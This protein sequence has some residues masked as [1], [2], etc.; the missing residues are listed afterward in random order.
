MSSSILSKRI[1]ENIDN[2]VSKKTNPIDN[3]LT[4][5]K[6]NEVGCNVPAVKRVYEEEIKL[7][8]E[9]SNDESDGDVDPPSLQSTNTKTI[10]GNSNC[11]ATESSSEPTDQLSTERNGRESKKIWMKA[12]SGKKEPRV[13]SNYQVDL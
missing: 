12:A 7:N 10:L 1:I 9:V 5:E 2:G 6:D 11:D 3:Q 4:F 13:G 8:D